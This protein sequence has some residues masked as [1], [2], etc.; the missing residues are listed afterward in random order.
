M[1]LRSIWDKYYQETQGVVFVVDSA[2]AARFEEARAA[3]G[4]VLSHADLA[5]IPVLV[6]VNKQDAVAAESVD[7]VTGALALRGP[8]DRPLR[9]QPASAL[10]CAGLEE[11]IR[12][13]VCTA[14]TT[15]ASM[16]REQAQS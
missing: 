16:A 4:S 10:T 9:I 5:A 8:P 12:W 7:A 2:D 1:S 11:G 14:Q 3:L 6:F 15:P 13:L